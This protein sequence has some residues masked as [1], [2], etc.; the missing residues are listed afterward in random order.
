MNRIANDD[1]DAWAESNLA[2]DRP[3]V[4]RAEDSHWHNRGARF[5]DDKAEPGEGGLQTSIRCARAFG[6]DQRRVAAAQNSNQ[7]LE[8]AGT[9]SF[10][11]D[12]NDIE[13][14]Q[15]PTEHGHF[16]ERF[17][18]EKINGTVAGIAA[19]RWIEK[20][21]M[22]HRKNDRAILDHAFAM[23]DAETVEELREQA[24]E[25]VTDPVVRIHRCN[26]SAKAKSLL[27]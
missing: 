27:I 8:R 3:G 2:V 15:E 11:I 21:L 25:I 10:E 22:V 12:G 4:E 1:G 18:G 14:R 16:H 7:R 23:Q 6:K 26:L 24:R 5:G 9:L 13:F 20:T 17:L 19:Q